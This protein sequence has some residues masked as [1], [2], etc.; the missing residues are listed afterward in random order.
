MDLNITNTCDGGFNLLSVVFRQFIDLV[1]VK[2]RSE[3]QITILFIFE[4]AIVS[5]EITLI[6]M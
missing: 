3:I 5:N 1:K 6:R 4:S 2:G